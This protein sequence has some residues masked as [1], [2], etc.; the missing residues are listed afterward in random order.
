LKEKQEYR[1]H[2]K[3]FVTFTF[4]VGLIVVAFF[5]VVSD[6][7]SYLRDGVTDLEFIISYL[8]VMINSLPMWFILAMLV[9]YIFAR[10][11]KEAALLGAIYTISAITFYFV[12]GHFYTDEG[13][14]F[15]FK[16]QAFVYVTWY[17]VSAIGG[18]FGGIVGLLMNAVFVKI[19]AFRIVFKILI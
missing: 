9:G 13:V 14:S 1:G 18:I 17:G 16:E 6:N 15:L 8:A 3:K 12:I 10:N 19:V 4:I 5:S 11:I 2:W 7:L